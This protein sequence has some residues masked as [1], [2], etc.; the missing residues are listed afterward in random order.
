MHEILH[1]L[2]L[3]GDKHASIAAFIDSRSPPGASNSIFLFISIWIHNFYATRI[4]QICEI[5]YSIDI[6]EHPKI[7]I[8]LPEARLK[9]KTLKIL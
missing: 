3:C 1:I 7:G 9:S 6:F 4:S 8:S 5:A 2:G